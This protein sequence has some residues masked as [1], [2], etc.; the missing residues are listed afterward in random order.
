MA[1]TFTN[2]LDTNV[3]SSLQ[4]LIS[5]EFTQPVYYDNEY[6]QRGTNWF[7]LVPVTDELEEDFSNSHTRAYEVLIQYYRIVSGDR[8]KDSHIDTVSAIM[9]R[10]KRLVRNNSDYRVDGEQRFFNGTIENVNYQPELE[11]VSS[12]VLL[13]EATFRANVFEVI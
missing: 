12:D 4:E 5:A 6:E 8:R 10:L 7:N 11:D 9:E 2:H 3:L 1:I 13:V